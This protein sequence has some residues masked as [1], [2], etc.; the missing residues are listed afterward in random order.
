VF[1][2]KI[3]SNGSRDVSKVAIKQFGAD[4]EY[5]DYF[6]IMDGF[7]SDEC[8]MEYVKDIVDGD[9]EI[10]RQL[11]E[12]TSIDE[13]GKILKENQGK[14]YIETYTFQSNG[15]FQPIE[16]FKS[17]GIGTYR[18]GSPLDDSI[19]QGGLYSLTR[20]DFEELTKNYPDLCGIVDGKPVIYDFKGFGKEV[21]SGCPLSD[22]DG[23]VLISSR[24]TLDAS[25]SKNLGMPSVLNSSA[26][27]ANFISGGKL[28][29][30]GH[31]I[32]IKPT[33]F[34]GNIHQTFMNVRNASDSSVKSISYT[35]PGSSI[36]YTLSFLSVVS[37]DVGLGS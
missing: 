19:R 8:A 33:E 24:V 21:L 35:A 23:A 7:I 34:T 31:E 11:R 30:R 25:T 32:I 10:V 12:A 6:P 14:V 37:R 3:E 27:D 1:R 15:G 29:S 22:A 20:R 4:G 2:L 36:D 28:G 17:I 13:M 16:K 9:P 5:N 18:D 26:Y